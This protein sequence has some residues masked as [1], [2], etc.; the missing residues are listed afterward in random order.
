MHSAYSSKMEQYAAL[1]Y[2]LFILF[3][4]DCVHIYGNNLVQVTQTARGLVTF[5]FL[6]GFTHTRSLKVGW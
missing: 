2:L 4:S 6:I 5:S 1:Y 3:D